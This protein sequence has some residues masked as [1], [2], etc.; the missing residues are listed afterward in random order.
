MS[1]IP[2]AELVTEVERLLMDD[3]EGCSTPSGAEHFNV[4]D[5]PTANW[6]VRKIVEAHQY[7]EHVK[8]WAEQECRRAQRDEERLMYMFG[9]QLEEW[10]KG[11]LA[12]T[13]GRRKSF[14]LP[15]GTVGFRHVNTAVV[16]IDEAAVIEWARSSQPKAIQ[17]KEFLSK[18][19]INE[20]FA[21][22]GEVPPGVH[23]EPERE[24]FYVK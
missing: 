8:E 10:V 14:T 6:V 17:T 16:V 15:A 4:S 23:V 5:E 2:A 21:A 12:A 7:R 19:A 1:V 22:F 13:N 18:T 3:G 11:R 20:H 9:R 24:K